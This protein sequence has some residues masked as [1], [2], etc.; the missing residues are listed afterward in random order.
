MTVQIALL[1][2]GEEVIADIKEFRD[3]D[4]NLVSYLFSEPYCIK[5]QTREILIEADDA[6]PKHELIFY[7]W[8]GLS[9]DKDLIV[10]KDWIVCIADPHDSILESYGKRTDGRDDTIDGPDDGLSI[11]TDA[12]G[13]TVSSSSVLNEQATFTESD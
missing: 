5:I 6:P 3:P 9:K 11:R 2:S 7:K 12:T 8:M 4:E 13:T 10:N 1:K